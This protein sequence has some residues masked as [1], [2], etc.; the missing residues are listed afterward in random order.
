MKRH[1]A[2]EDYLK[3]IRILQAELPNVRSVDVA[4]RLHVSKPSV[5]YAVSILKESNLLYTDENM[6]LHLT[7]EG[8]KIADQIFE[9]HVF[10]TD[11]LIDCGVD[12]KTAHT[13]ACRLEHAICSESFTLLKETWNS[14]KPTT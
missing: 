13:D 7:E 12:P 6:F 5:C 14:R 4:A 8:R 1:T 3:T 10:F 9:R 2:G 11:M